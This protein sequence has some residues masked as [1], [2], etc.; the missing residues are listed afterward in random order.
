MNELINVL[1]A[2]DHPIVRQGLLAVLVPRN[3]MKVVGEASN[4]AEAVALACTLH[5]DVILMDLSMPEMSGVEAT[6]QILREYPKA[7]V[8]ILTSFGTDEMAGQAIR[9]GA[10][11][12]LMKETPPDDLLHAIR[13]VHIGQFTIPQNVAQALYKSEPASK[14]A[15]NALTEREE[16]VLRLITD[17][18]TNRQ[19]AIQ[20]NIGE[21]TVRTHVGSLLRKLELS[22]RTEL[23][24]YAIRRGNHRKG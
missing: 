10:M 20:L 5:P 2:D 4:G 14:D 15:Q 23:A 24:I 6:S 12:F 17:G 9:A 11:G 21:N 18:L 1:I 3:G 7:R 19:I 22:N 8:L 16:E 13:S